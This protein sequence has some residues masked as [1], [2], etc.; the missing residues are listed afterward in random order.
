MRTDSIPGWLAQH[1]WPVW[2]LLAVVAVCVVLLRLSLWTREH[3]LRRRRAGITQETFTGQLQQ[4]GFDAVITSATFRYMREVQLVPFPILPGDQLEEDLGL[5]PEEI[6]QSVRDLS[7]ALRREYS[8][9]LQ[10]L[11]LVTVEDLIRLL[12]ASPRSVR[13]GAA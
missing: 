12:Q 8:P 10:P 9:G 2:L 4:Y 5:G 11:P 3:R 7:L 13:T 1:A 6:E